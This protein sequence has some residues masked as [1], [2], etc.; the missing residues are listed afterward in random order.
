MGHPTGAIMSQAE[1]SEGA[2]T[3]AIARTLKRVEMGDTVLD[4]ANGKDIV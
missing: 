4:N 2:T 1:K 3:R